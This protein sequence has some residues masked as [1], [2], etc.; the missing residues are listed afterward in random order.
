MTFPIKTTFNCFL[1]KIIISTYFLGFQN[2][3][4]WA[5][6]FSTQELNFI[7]KVNI[8]NSFKLQ[9][10]VRKPCP[11]CF[12]HFCLLQKSLFWSKSSLCQTERHPWFCSGLYYSGHICSPLQRSFTDFCAKSTVH[13]DPIYI[14]FL[15]RD[16]NFTPSVKSRLLL[17]QHIVGFFLQTLDLLITFGFNPKDVS[18]YMASSI[19][20]KILSN[21][22]STVT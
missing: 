8:T 22:F 13:V 6:N 1:L 21:I 3:P 15:P 19:S 12:T 14:P 9:F 4:H 5:Y 17:K 11:Y 2:G 10:S 7:W 18:A 20:I 16:L